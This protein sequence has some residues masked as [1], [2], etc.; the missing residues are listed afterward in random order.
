MKLTKKVALITG[1]SSGIG[2]ET[3][4]LFARRGAKVVVTYNKSKKEAEEVFEK[5]SEL[6]ECLLIKLNVRDD[7]SIHEAI[8][9]TIEHFKGI[10]ILVNNAG[11]ASVKNFD[12]QS[13]K[14]IQ[15][16]VEVNLT[17]AMKMTSMALPYLEEQKEAYII[18]VAS[19]YGKEVDSEI[20][21]YCA[22]KFGLRGF[23]Q[24]LAKELPN[25]IKIFSVN[26][27][28]TATQM[29]NFKGIEPRLVG[30]VIAQ[31]VE[32]KINKE[33]GSDVD[34]DDYF[35]GNRKKLP[36]S[37]EKAEEEGDEEELEEKDEADDEEGGVSPPKGNKAAYVD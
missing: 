26:P 28:L 25:M 18:N 15:E 22:T 14:E 30:D 35:E 27:G 19:M 29:S 34:V 13:F 5:C 4:I 31:V 3:A 33:S 2:R 36:A 7:K 24:A 23:S 17:G 1:S 37:N 20:A 21:P 10:D 8:E 16:Q 9:K 12:K 32:G 6:S 11:V